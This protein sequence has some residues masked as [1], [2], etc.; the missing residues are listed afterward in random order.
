M[1]EVLPGVF[2]VPANEGKGFG[3]AHFVKRP[4]GNLFL[5]ASRITSFSDEFGALEAEG[6]IAA[7]VISDRHLGGP[8]TNELATRF[9]AEV[10]CSRIEAEAV[11][12]RANAVTIDHA[13]PYERTTILGD[14]QLIPTPGH[15]AGQ[16]GTLCDVGDRRILFTS[17][18]VWRVDGQWRPG[19]TSRRKMQPAFEAL[20][21]LE[22]DTVVPWTGYSHTEFYVDA[23]DV[24]ATVDAM[25]AGCPKP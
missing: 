7:I 22:F 1:R 8:P 3:Y 17:D 10:Y 19:N 16:F 5:D 13:L 23:P 2:I 6:G 4:G 11:G 25:I 20:R 12:H 14:V 9:G 24:G 21:D 18:F 15:T